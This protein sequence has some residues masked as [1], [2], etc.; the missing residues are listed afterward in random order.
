MCALISCA[1]LPADFNTTVLH[2]P[3]RLSFLFSSLPPHTAFVPPLA[4]CLLSSLLTPR[5]SFL[6]RENRSHHA[7]LK[8]APQDLSPPPHRHLCVLY[9]LHA[10]GARA[11]AT[12]K[13]STHS[14]APCPLEARASLL[15]VNR[16]RL[17]LP[18]P[19][20]TLRQTPSMVTLG[21]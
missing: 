11:R 14:V 1:C 7:G 13:T 18:A 6:V 20:L 3:G 8:R 2:L 21:K 12:T 15:R 9:L 17:C 10:P 5:L 16:P 19:R 4:A